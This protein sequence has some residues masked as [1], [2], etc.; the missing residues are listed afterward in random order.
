MHLNP[1]ITSCWTPSGEQIKVESAGD[2]EKFQLFGS[3][4]YR[5]GDIIFSEQERK[6]TS[7]YISHLE[8]LL[9]KYPASPIILITDNY[10][11]H[12]TKAVK[13]L[14]RRHFGRLLQ[15]YLP[16]YS[17]HLNPIEMLWRYVRRLVTHNHK[18]DTIAAVMEAVRRVLEELSKHADQVISIIGGKPLTKAEAT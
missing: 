18:F 16:T 5:T 6:R 15:V 1:T 7:E 8:Q 2:D 10:S 4:N 3:V 17:P 13:E 14:E 12:K 9:S 11:I